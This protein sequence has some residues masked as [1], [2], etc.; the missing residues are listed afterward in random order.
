MEDPIVEVRFAIDGMER[1]KRSA[2]SRT[3]NDRHNASNAG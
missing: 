3:A 2:G 1:S